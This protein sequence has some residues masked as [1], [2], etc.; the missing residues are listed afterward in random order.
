[1][2]LPGLAAGR[3]L[4]DQSDSKSPEHESQTSHHVTELV[5]PEPDPQ[6]T[7]NIAINVPE[8]VSRLNSLMDEDHHTGGAVSDSEAGQEHCKEALS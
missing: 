3:W 5:D 7:R 1:M 2:P 4:T 6:E 8:V